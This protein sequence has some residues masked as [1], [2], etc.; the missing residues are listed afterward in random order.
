MGRYQKHRCLVV[1]MDTAGM[2]MTQNIIGDIKGPHHMY[3]YLHLA[4]AY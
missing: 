3:V 4:A 1:A 2:S